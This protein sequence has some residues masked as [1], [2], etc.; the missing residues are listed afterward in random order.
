M[1]TT[2]P[3]PGGDGVATGWSLEAIGLLGLYG[4][5]GLLCLYGALL[6]PTPV[7]PRA[8]NAVLAGVAAT[9]VGLVLARRGRVAAWSVHLLLAV[10][11][12]G[13]GVSAGAAGTHAGALASGISAIWVSLY[14]ALCLGRRATR[15][16]GALA[17]TALAF[18]VNRSVGG[19]A[20]W[21][22]WAVVALSA[23]VAGELLAWAHAGVRLSART[24]ALTGAANRTGLQEAAEVL[25]RP[26]RRDPVP[27][28]VA[29]LDLD[30][31]KGVN[32][33]AGH[34]E[35]DRVLT[36]LVE[37]WRAAMRSGDVLARTG[38]DEFVMLLPA[39]DREAASALLHRLQTSSQGAWSFGLAERV[40][41]DDLAA[42]LERADAD[43]YAQ[44]Q[45]R[46]T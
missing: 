9:V 14:A 19:G 3:R 34:A 31:F 37:E 39:T 6:P 13:V 21:A 44:K 17:V 24:D 8:T 20:G 29:V 42:M 2:V 11:S 10:F 38:G 1:R 32:D 4:V 35:G 5:S 27:L 43:L 12:V 33:R 46:A 45:R 25:L 36:A 7:T 41:G 16:H 22:A 30:D 15:L 40:P 28:T 18:G 23:L 26:T